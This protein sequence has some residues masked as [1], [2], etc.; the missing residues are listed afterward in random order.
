MSISDILSL[1]PYLLLI[2]IPYKDEVIFVAA[3][4]G[5]LKLYFTSV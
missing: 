3:S 4:G 2:N 1:I 5:S